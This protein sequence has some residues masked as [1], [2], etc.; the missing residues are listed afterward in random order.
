MP[1]FFARTD[2]AIAHFGAKPSSLNSHPPLCP[3]RTQHSSANN[4]ALLTP[5]PS[6]WRRDVRPSS[7][8]VVPKKLQAKVIRLHTKSPP[9]SLLV[10]CHNLIFTRAAASKA[11]KPNKNLDPTFPA[12][13]V[14]AGSKA[15][16]YP[17][18]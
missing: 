17:D 4:R 13:Q 10:T 6:G 12:Q 18:A 2:N 9:R 15:C 1:P 8:C 3:L 14:M 7:R 11:K 5:F 16:S